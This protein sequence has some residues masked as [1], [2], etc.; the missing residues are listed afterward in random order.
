MLFPVVGDILELVYAM[1][2][3][4]LLPEY[5]RYWASR[6][7]PKFILFS[8]KLSKELNF[9]SRKYDENQNLTFGELTY[10]FL[11]IFASFISSQL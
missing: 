6:V 7:G 9:P 10:L 5:D 8:E 4:Y 2:S 3:S 11:E 1:L